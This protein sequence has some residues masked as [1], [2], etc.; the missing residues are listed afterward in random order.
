[1]NLDLYNG[2][3]PNVFVVVQATASG[4]VLAETHMEQVSAIPPDHHVPAAS[5]CWEEIGKTE[6]I[7]VSREREREGEVEDEG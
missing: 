7:E 4:A 6:V 2:S 1:M 5:A 3:K